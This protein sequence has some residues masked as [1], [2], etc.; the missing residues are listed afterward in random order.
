MVVL[1]EL[2]EVLDEVTVKRRYSGVVQRGDTVRFD[3]G[4][5][6]TGTETTVADVLRRLPGVEVADNGQVS[7][8]GKAVDRVLLD[9]KDMFGGSSG[10]L[11]VNNLSADLMTG[12][13]MLTDYKEGSLADDYKR[14]R[15]LALNIKTSG[16][17]RLT[18]NA[19]AGGG[20]REKYEGKAVLIGIGEDF[21]ANVLLSANNTGTPVFTM[22]DYLQNIYGMDN[23]L[24]QHTERQLD[25]ST[26]RWP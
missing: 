21:S 8:G 9:G 16:G 2:A 22:N 3:I 20:Y 15:Q 5:F 7:Y 24:A 19:S 10:N 25:I 26:R 18:G 11:A 1:H 6:K 23:L 14:Q 12:A 4:H 17:R 13:E